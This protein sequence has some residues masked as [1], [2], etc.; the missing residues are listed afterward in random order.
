MEDVIVRGK[1]KDRDGL[2]APA[3]LKHSMYWTAEDNEAATIDGT[4]LQEAFGD[5]YYDRGSPG[6]HMYLNN[7]SDP[8]QLFACQ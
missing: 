1:K 6:S 8:K 4:S 5:W 2:F 3:C 7:A